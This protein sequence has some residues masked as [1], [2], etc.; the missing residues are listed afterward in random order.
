ME[1]EEHEETRQ[2]SEVV[3]PEHDQA[4]EQSENAILQAEKF[5]AKI[6]NPP[7]NISDSPN[8][9]LGMVNFNN[10]D[11]IANVNDIEMGFRQQMNVSSP[12]QLVPAPL[13]I[14]GVGGAHW[15]SDDD[16]FH[17]ICHIDQNLKEKIERGDYVDLDKL[18][19]HDRN[20]RTYAYGNND[21]TND[22]G[23]T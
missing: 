20:S 9:E 17:L 12:P 4:K 11:R 3:I 6:A 15:L 7:G 18:L 2:V 21:S 5:K 16:F 19:I 23:K 14:G 8:T 22:C 13:P 1:H 10:E